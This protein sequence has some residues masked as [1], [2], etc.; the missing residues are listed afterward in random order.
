MEKLVK[1]LDLTGSVV[2]AALLIGS[3]T[4]FHSNNFDN[5]TFLILAAIYCRMK[6]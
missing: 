6:S 2:S 5:A 1:F 4:E 3:A